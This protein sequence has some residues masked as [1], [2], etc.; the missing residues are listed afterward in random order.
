MRPQPADRGFAIL[1][2][3]R[4]N[5]VLTQSVVNARHGVTA[6]EIAQRRAAFLAA[7][8][9][10]AAVNP[11]DDRHWIRRARRKIEIQFLTLMPLRNISDVA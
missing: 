9:P 5:R 10:R 3:R 11:N 1:D 8:F 7:T 2:L 6:L 4:K